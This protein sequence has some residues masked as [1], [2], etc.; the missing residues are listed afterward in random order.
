MLPMITDEASDLHVLMRPRHMT[1]TLLAASSMKV[2]Q[3]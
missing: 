2:R 1:E 3:V